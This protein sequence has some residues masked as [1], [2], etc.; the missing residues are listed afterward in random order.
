MK[1]DPEVYESWERVCPKCK[2]S[3][4]ELNPKTGLCLR[5]PCPACKSSP[6]PG[7]IGGSRR[8]EESTGTNEK[9]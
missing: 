4:Y 5:S 9:A 2:G 1:D 3:A 7:F 6:W 8:V